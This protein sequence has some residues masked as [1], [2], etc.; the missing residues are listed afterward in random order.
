M[1]YSIAYYRVYID[2]V[3]EH[4]LIIAV[5]GLGKIS[6]SL[7]LLKAYIQGN[8]TIQL[9]LAATIPDWLFGLYFV[10]LWSKLNFTFKA[11]TVAV[12]SND[13]KKD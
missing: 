3:Q 6:A 10:Y 7:L 2:G 4:P 11:V 9:L 8:T 12:V 13:T 5:G 1:F